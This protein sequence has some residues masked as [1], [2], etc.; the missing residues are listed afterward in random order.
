MWSRTSPGAV[1][2]LGSRTPPGGMLASPPSRA[3]PRSRPLEALRT[4]SCTCSLARLK[5]RWRFSRLLLFGLS[6][7]STM[8]ME[9]PDACSP[10]LLAPH[11]PVDQAAHLALGVAARLHAL[12]ELGVLLVALAVLLG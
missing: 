11:V 1:R 3:L 10:G 9:T 5:K 8:C 6:R 4:A 12:D 2:S 7:R